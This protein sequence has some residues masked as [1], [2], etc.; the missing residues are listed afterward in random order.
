MY[1]NVQ[2]VETYWFDGTKI[3]S[4]WAI[5]EVWGTDSE[6]AFYYSRL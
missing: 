3:C 5:F 6:M 4:L 2:M 1:S